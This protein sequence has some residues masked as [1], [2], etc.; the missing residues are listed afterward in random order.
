MTDNNSPIRIIIVDDHAM[1]RAGLATFLEVSDG[2]ALVGEANNGQE[3]IALC[4]NTQPDVAL[5]DLV[6][7]DMSGVET[8]RIIRERWPGTQVIV[9]T[10]FQCQSNLNLCFGEKPR[11]CLRSLLN[12]AS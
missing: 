3:A 2:I 9:L 12:K 5:M 7:P 4:E 8:T 6:M 1:V 10:S 11:H